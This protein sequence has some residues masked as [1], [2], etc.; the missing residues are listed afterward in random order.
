MVG[1]T[2]V[3]PVANAPTLVEAA[4]RAKVPKARRDRT[5]GE[6]ATAPTA[7]RRV[8]ANPVRRPVVPFGFLT[9]TRDIPAGG[10]TNP[11]PRAT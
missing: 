5:A 8:F 9:R 10:D 11:R 1:S 7:V 4:R 3:T 6:A 2:L